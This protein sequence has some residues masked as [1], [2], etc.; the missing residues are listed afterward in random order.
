MKEK[1]FFFRKFRE[2]IKKYPYRKSGVRGI[3]LFGLR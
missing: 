1:I 3:Q 2:R